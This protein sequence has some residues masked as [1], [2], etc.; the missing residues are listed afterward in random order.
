MKGIHM[1]LV[2]LRSG[3]QNQ[4]WKKSIII[5]LKTKK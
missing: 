2:A 1:I 3:R 5:G 4:L